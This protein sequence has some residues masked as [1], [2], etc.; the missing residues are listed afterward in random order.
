MNDAVSVPFELSM[1][2]TAADDDD[3]QTLAL[4]ETVARALR[5]SRDQRRAAIST[6]P[7][8]NSYPRSDCEKSA[9]D[10]SNLVDGTAR[11]SPLTN[12]ASMS[13]I[14]ISNALTPSPKP[15]C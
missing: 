5:R 6:A 10:A 12:V 9:A 7:P 2:P 11:V 13:Y 14:E 15:L 8:G 1:A 3:D 4:A